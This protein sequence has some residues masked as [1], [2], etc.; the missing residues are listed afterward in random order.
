MYYFQTLWY[1]TTTIPSSKW[2][3][4]AFMHWRWLLIDYYLFEFKCWFRHWFRFLKDDG[5][6]DGGDIFTITFDILEE[7]LSLA[8]LDI[9]SHF[10][11]WFIISATAFRLAQIGQALRNFNTFVS[12]KIILLKRAHYWYFEYIAFSLSAGRYIHF[13]SHITAE[14]MPLKIF[15]FWNFIVKI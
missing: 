10:Y 15:S 14:S 1:Y 11:H 4:Y 7:F 3:Q 5:R 12:R 13:S 2:R 9:D 8:P 6:W